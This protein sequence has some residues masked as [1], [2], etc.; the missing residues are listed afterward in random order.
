MNEKVG[1]EPKFN[2]ALAYPK[3]VRVGQSV[4]MGGTTAA[5]P[6]GA[7]GGD[8]V[9]AQTTEVIRRIDIALRQV[10]SR[11]DEIVRIRVYVTDIGRWPEIVTVLRQFFPHRP[12]ATLVEV[13][14]LLSPSLLVEMEAD[15][16]VRG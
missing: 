12:A 2:E 4:W 9:I 11:L 8:D 10:G 15:A 6:D 14:R 3:A 5:G 7:V 1:T 16:V 13:S